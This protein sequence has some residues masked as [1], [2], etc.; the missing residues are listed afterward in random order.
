[1]DAK[2]AMNGK[3]IFKGQI[4]ASLISEFMPGT[5]EHFLRPIHNDIGYWHVVEAGSWED[6]ASTHIF[7]D[8]DEVVWC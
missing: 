2:N 4:L 6:S 8:F 1:M 5:A 3:P 7:V